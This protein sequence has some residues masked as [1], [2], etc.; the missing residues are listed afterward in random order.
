MGEVI[1]KTLRSSL[2]SQCGFVVQVL[3]S[4]HLLRRAGMAASSARHTLVTCGPPPEWGQN[5]TASNCTHPS[6]GWVLAMH[7]HSLSFCGGR[8]LHRGRFKWLA[9]T[10][11][12]SNYLQL[13]GACTEGG[14][15]RTWEPLLHGLKFAPLCETKGPDLWRAGRFCASAVIGAPNVP[16][17]TCLSMCLLP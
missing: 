3:L 6:P 17:V 5:Q 15:E 2:M 8:W 1:G 14:Q 10:I 12:P 16:V 9:R 11:C 7:I 4:R 13:L